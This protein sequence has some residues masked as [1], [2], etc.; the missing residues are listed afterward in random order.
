MDQAFSTSFQPDVWRTE[1]ASDPAVPAFPEQLDFVNPANPQA[2]FSFAFE[3]AGG[4]GNNIIEAFMPRELE[5]SVFDVIGR[6]LDN[7]ALI[8]EQE[9]DQ[10]DG[11][12]GGTIGDFRI[13]AFE[14]TNHQTGKSTTLLWSNYDFE[15][16]L[17]EKD[18]NQNALKRLR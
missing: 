9:D 1:S 18:F 13:D 4:S 16:E 10:Q 5:L 8:T 14:V 11:I 7:L 17:D 15:T 12:V 2:F 6:Y 3:V